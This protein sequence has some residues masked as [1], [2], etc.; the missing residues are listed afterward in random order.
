MF[1]YIYKTTNTINNKIYI[2]QHKSSIF[3]PLNYIGSGT[4]LSRAINK[5]GIENFKNELICECM[6]QEELDEK[7]I[8]WISFYNSTDLSIGY[9]I[10]DGGRG[11]AGPRSDETKEKIRLANTGKTLVNDGNIC[12]KISQDD[13]EEFL[14]L[15]YNYGPLPYVRSDSFKNKVKESLTGKIG[16]SKGDLKTKIDKEQLPE[17]ISNG[18]VIG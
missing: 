15:G 12:F 6:S 8:Y 9:N 2:G 4:L 16:V 10:T 18:Y 13:L 7:E 11:G 5:Y 3:E 17:Y 14:S 1:G